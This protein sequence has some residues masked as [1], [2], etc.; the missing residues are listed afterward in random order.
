[1][2]NENTLDGNGF[3]TEAI[4]TEL[5]P[6]T[7]NIAKRIKPLIIR[8]IPGF[9]WVLLVRIAIEAFIVWLK[10]YFTIP[11][12]LMS[13]TIDEFGLVNYQPL[14]MLS[15]GT[16]YF[17]TGTCINATNAQDGQIMILYMNADGNKYCREH[18]EF[19]IKFVGI[20]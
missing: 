9:I 5:A 17:V 13:E 8:L 20:K 16:E 12:M 2:I 11:A 1:M 14:Q 7:K 6:R 10:D 18:D 4:A 15:E 3:D 19:N